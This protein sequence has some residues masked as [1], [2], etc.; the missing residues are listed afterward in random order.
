MKRIH[1]FEFEDLQWFPSFLRNYMT[2]YLQFISNYAKIYSPIADLLINKLKA[3]KSTNVIDLASG[4]GGGLLWLNNKILVHIPELTIT[5]TD[6][7]PNINA[8]K[9]TKLKAKNFNYYKERIDARD[10]PEYLKGFRTQFLSL[11]HFRPN[12]AQK[13]L[14]NAIDSNTPIGIFEAQDR[15]V[16]SILGMLLSPVSVLLVTPFIKPFKF[17]RF[18]YTYLCPII[19][20][21][22]MWDGLVSCLRTYSIAEMNELVNKL[23]HKEHFDWEIGIKK[24][25]S[26]K[27]MFLIGTPKE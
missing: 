20:L 12:D 26:K 9:E 15:T 17:G 7:F 24:E 11:H 4:G 2:D 22:V 21:V 6:Y 18:F 13:I 23:H 27:V 10:V 14:Q 1:L 8:F 19:P 3:T 25:K 16:S 5:L